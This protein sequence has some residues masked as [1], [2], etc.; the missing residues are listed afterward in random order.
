MIRFLQL[1]IIILFIGLTSCKDKVADIPIENQ[2]PETGLFLYPDNSI[3]SQ[4]SK[5]N[6]HWW[7]DDPDGLIV[8]F[9]FSFDKINWTFTNLNDSLFALQI[10]AKDTNYTF[11]VSAVDNNG[12]GIYDSEINQNG[13]SY[14]AEPFN[15]LNGNKIHDSNET[16]TDIGLI[17]P[18]PAKQDFPIQNSAPIIFWNELSILPDTSFPVMSFGWEAE[19]IDGN[20]T[21]ETI[22][23]SL[24]DTSN[25]SNIVSLNGAVRRITLRAND[26]QSSNPLMEIMIDGSEANINLQKLPGL[27]FN[28]NNKLFVQ[29]V[30][31]SGAKSKYIVLPDSNE[32]WYVKKPKG[33]ILI[34]DD[35]STQDNSDVF[36]NSVFDSLGLTGKFD[37]YDFHK[38]APPYINVT[39]LETLK[40]FD[41]LF[42]YSDNNPSLDL[43]SNSTQKYLDAGGKVAFSLQFPQTVDLTF[44]QSFLPI[45]SDSSSFRISLLGGT[46]I[47]SYSPEYPNL[48]LSSGIFRVRSFYLNTLG[49]IPIYYFPDKELNGFIGFSSTDKKIF[50]IG[51]PLS[52]S[53]GGN[54]NV[55]NLLDHIFFD[56][57]GL[58]P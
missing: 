1:L 15:D 56:D 8:G 9:Y 47:T 25:L 33:K 58:M 39:F 26:F 31:I 34:V 38:Q 17:D 41:Y 16:F 35:Y 2:P 23:I 36:Y 46:K 12:N 51:V 28:D 29:A 19:D 53:N 20:E 13:I 22:N 24:N 57:F 32:T 10:G 44:L 49:A 18:T 27:K 37:V 54:A 55:K 52:K 45:T 43:A 5:I 6:I 30:D 11:Y 7:G 21:I 42:W 40:L 14:G 3:N 4:P 48:E 50:F